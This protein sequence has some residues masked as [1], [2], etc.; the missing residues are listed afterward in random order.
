MYKPYSSYAQTSVDWVGDLP[1]HWQVQKINELFIERRVKVSDTDYPPLSVTKFGIV[2]QLSDAVKSKD[3]DNRKLVLRGDFVINSRSDRKSSSGISRYDG[4]VSLIN[5]VLQPRESLFG[6]YYHYLLRSHL[7]AEEYY[8]NGRGIVADLWTTRYSEM[9][10]IWLPVPPNDEQRAIAA[11]L[12][13]KTNE[14]NRLIP[15]KA[16]TKGT[17][18]AQS[19]SLFSRELM[20]LDEYRTKLISDVATGKIDIR[21]IQVPS[22]D[23]VEDETVDLSAEEN[24][25]VDETEE[26]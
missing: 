22:Y 1:S 17:V 23:I 10:T 11:F 8:R 5:I 9:K 4:S 6:D 14:I 19:K 15:Y 12:D 3:G 20:L 18:I 7:F 13:W 24:P 2:P 25:N 21:E 26:E 16:L